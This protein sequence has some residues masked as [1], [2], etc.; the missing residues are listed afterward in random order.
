MIKP[1][2]T[3]LGMDIKKHPI[4]NKASYSIVGGKKS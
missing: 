2:N 1:K 3:M 4:L